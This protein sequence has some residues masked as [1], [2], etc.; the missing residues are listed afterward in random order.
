MGAYKGVDVYVFD[1]YPAIG[2]FKVY[3][4]SRGL[5]KNEVAETLD[6]TRN[7]LSHIK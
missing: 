4:F 5:I 2:S 6:D 7:A 3:L 1:R